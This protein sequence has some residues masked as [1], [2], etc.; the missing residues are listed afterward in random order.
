MRRV[1]FAVAIVCGLLANPS[2]AQ[3][4]PAMRT[5]IDVDQEL[6]QK[7]N[8]T[9]NSVTASTLA[10]MRYNRIPVTEE[11]SAPSLQLTIGGNSTTSHC[12]AAVS[13]TISRFVPLMFNLNHEV[14]GEATYCGSQ[15][16]VISDKWNFVEGVNGLS[17]QAIEECLAELQTYRLSNP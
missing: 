17:K 16:Y 10:S 5:L 8:L 4:L 7:C 1:T 15:G 14:L 9:V 12:F 3:D 2:F 13:I 6:Q 11:K